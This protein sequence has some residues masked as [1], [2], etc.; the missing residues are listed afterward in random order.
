VQLGAWTQLLPLL[1]ADAASS[2][3]LRLKSLVLPG[4]NGHD[5][6]RHR[7]HD[8]FLCRLSSLSAPPALQRFS[9][10]RTVRH[11]VAGLLSVVSLPHLMVLHL[12]GTVRRMSSSTSWRG[13]PLWLLLLSRWSSLTTRLSLTATEGQRLSTAGSTRRGQCGGLLLSRLTTLRHLSCNSYIASEAVGLQDGLQDGEAS[14]YRDKLYSLSYIC[15][16]N[17]CSASLLRSPSLCSL[18]SMSA[19]A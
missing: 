14:G 16:C 17:R 4:N 10:V 15:L 5:D 13:S 1:C 3:L 12:G 11:R 9:G 2:L 6:S 19:A 8:A 7:A 18:S